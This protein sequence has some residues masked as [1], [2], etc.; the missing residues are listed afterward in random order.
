M[1]KSGGCGRQVGRRPG[2]GGAGGRF[3][4]QRAAVSV[5]TTPQPW[6][7]HSPDGCSG[8]CS[9]PLPPLSTISALLGI[10]GP[11]APLGQAIPCMVLVALRSQA[12]VRV[13]L[14]LLGGGVG[15][16]GFVPFWGARISWSLCLCLPSLCDCICV[17]VYAR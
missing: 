1:T 4:G 16:L 2:G 7:R 8:V 9:P 6:R 14:A 15:G 10:S 3:H 5:Q 13:V 17:D 11:D 12:V